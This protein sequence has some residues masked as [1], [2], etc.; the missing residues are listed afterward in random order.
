[1][2]DKKGRGGLLMPPSTGSEGSVNGGGLSTLW[3]NNGSGNGRRGESGGE[4]TV[5]SQGGEQ[6]SNSSK[7]VSQQSAG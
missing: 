1:M 7:F 5:T 2:V 4:A 3:K 6:G